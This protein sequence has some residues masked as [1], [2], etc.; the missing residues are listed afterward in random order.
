MCRGQGTNLQLKKQQTQT[1]ENTEKNRDIAGGVASLK[2]L[3]TK[4]K[5]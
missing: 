4:N 1:H 5:Q 2:M 3:F